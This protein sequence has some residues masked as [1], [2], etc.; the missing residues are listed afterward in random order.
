MV[1]NFA[2]ERRGGK[3]FLKR[4]VSL[5]ERERVFPYNIAMV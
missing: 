4:G 5:F 3:V 1:G 2:Y